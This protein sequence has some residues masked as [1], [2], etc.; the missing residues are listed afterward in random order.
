MDRYEGFD[1]DAHAVNVRTGPTRLAVEFGSV[2]PTLL[3]VA[4]DLR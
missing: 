3:S 4:T 2:K 1:G